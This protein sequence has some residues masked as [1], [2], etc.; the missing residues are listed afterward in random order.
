MT[1][2]NLGGGGPR[3]RTDAVLGHR[4]QQHTKDSKKV[5][6]KVYFDSDTSPGVV[7]MGYTTTL[8]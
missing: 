5:G 2:T 7:Y 6:Y 3:S 8:K 4:R 1:T